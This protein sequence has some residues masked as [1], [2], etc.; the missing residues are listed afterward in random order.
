[1]D[2]GA[3]QLQTMGHK[4]LDMTEVTAWTE[5]LSHNNIKTMHLNMKIKIR[6]SSIIFKIVQLLE[7]RW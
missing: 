6:T 2:R 1:M 7:R 4:E 5:S 3:W